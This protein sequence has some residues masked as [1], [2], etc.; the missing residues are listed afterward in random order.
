MTTSLRIS[1]LSI[2]ATFIA[3][4]AGTGHALADE[5]K[6]VDLAVQNNK[7]TRILATSM[8]YK[9]ANDNV[10][11][12]EDFNDVEVASGDFETIAIDQNLSG[13]EGNRLIGLRLHFEAK[14]GGKWSV[15]L[16]SGTDDVFDD[17]SVCQ[18]F[19]GR[20]Y[21][22]DLSSSDVCNEN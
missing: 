16:L 9:F 22:L 18:S 17:T 7:A 15:P 8:D 12:N 11:R 13:G 5:C 3:A 14:C 20:S 6:H 4:T 21:R 2:L 10:W 1:R 19:S